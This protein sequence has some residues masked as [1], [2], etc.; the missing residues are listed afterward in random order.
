MERAVRRGL[1][2]VGDPS[3]GRLVEVVVGGTTITL[4]GRV[5]SWAGHLAAQSA[6]WS[7]PGITDVVNELQVGECAPASL[8]APAGLTP[9]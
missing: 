2:E 3:E 4:K 1:K 7:V 6:T 5:D 9:P 8:A